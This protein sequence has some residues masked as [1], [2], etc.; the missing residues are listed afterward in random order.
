[1]SLLS[2]PFSQILSSKSRILFSAYFWLPKILSQSYSLLANAIKIHSNASWHSKN[3][4]C[5]IQVR[6]IFAKSRSTRHTPPYLKFYIKCYI[7]QNLFCCVL[8]FRVYH[9]RQSHRVLLRFSMLVSP[10]EMM[11]RNYY[12][13]RLLLSYFYFLSLFSF[14]LQMWANICEA[15]KCTLWVGCKMWN[16]HSSTRMN[17]WAGVRWHHTQIEKVKDK[18]ESGVHIYDKQTKNPGKIIPIATVLLY[19]I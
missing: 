14:F 19:W 9:H 18:N 17:Q 12:L 4:S 13:Q 11:Q 7:I 16:K 15:I 1:M 2:P 8:S 6:G 5:R 10:W 3:I